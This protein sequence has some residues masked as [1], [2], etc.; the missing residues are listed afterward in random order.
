MSPSAQNFVDRAFDM[1][2][3]CSVKRRF[4]ALQHNGVEIALHATDE[5][6][7]LAAEMMSTRWGTSRK[8]FSIVEVWR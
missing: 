7:K 5:D 3:G 4:F 6:A 2:K 1:S 8:C